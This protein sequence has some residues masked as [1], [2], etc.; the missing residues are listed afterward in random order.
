VRASVYMMPGVVNLVGAAGTVTWAGARLPLH[1]ACAF[2]CSSHV[3][4]SCNA[5]AGSCF[6]HPLAYPPSST[7]ALPLI[8][9]IRRCE[10]VSILPGGS[11][12]GCDCGS[13]PGGT[14]GLVLDTCWRTDDASD[15]GHAHSTGMAGL[16]GR[17]CHIQQP[18]HSDSRSC[19]TCSHN[20]AEG[21]GQ[22]GWVVW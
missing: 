12:M 18:K 4:V 9:I 17:L 3:M 20:Q 5:M 6:Q 13:A 11:S 21:D 15:G 14:Q 1:V 7:S 16:K 19:N 8:A 22:E 10:F 2:A